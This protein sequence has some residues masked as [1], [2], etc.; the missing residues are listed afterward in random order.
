MSAVLEAQSIGITFQDNGCG[1]NPEYM[2][3]VKEKFYKGD[4][5]KP[6]SG[7]GLALCE[8]IM[9]LYKGMLSVDSVYEEGTRVI[10][11]LPV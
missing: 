9:H 10:L 4:K 5:A 11:A 2:M 6:G 3:H 8:E 7:I 1:I